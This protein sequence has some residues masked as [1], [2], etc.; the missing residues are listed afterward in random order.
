MAI[1]QSPSEKISDA[2]AEYIR[3]NEQDYPS[4]SVMTTEFIHRFGTVTID[5]VPERQWTRY[6]H[7]CERREFWA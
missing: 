7:D 3:E 1:L 2:L 6:L 4:V 5:D